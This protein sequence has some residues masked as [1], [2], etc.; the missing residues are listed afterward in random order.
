MNP[1]YS[2]LLIRH[3]QLNTKPVK[4]IKDELRLM[5]MKQ[6]LFTYEMTMSSKD[7]FESTKEA[8]VK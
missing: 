7:I 3:Y 4:T 1:N 2:S 5:W 6:V 8:F